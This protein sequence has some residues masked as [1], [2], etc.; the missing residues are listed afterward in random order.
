M[1]KN[2]PVFLL[3]TAAPIWAS[4]QPAFEAGDRSL[5]L[6]GGD[7]SL[8]PKLEEHGVVFKD[9]GAAEDIFKIFRAHNANCV[10]LRLFVHPDGRNGVV[11]DLPYT[12]ALAQ[13]VKAAGLLFS[14]DFH[15]SDTWAD[16]AHQTRPAAWKD[17]SFP[18]L[19]IKARQYTAETLR[20]FKDAGVPPDVVQIGNEI[21]NGMMWP[22]TDF[23][24]KSTSDSIHFDRL[25]Q[26]LAAC[27]EGVHLGLGPD[28]RTKIMIHLSSGSQKAITQWFFDNITKRRVAFDIIGLSYYPFWAGNLDQ[29][30]ETLR[31]TALTYGKPVAVVETAY[32]HED[33]PEWKGK[34][35]LVWPHTP[36]G[37]RIYLHDL[38][39]AVR[40]TPRG[41][42]AG[43][44]YWY[45]ESIAGSPGSWFEGQLALFDRNGNAL[46]ALQEF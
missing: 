42:G 14:L 45:P 23:E 46:P 39:A 2:F 18:E 7:I 10:R 40:E 8:A 28:S 4:V 11:N 34:K 12:I 17:L 25:A 5:F 1:T 3:L 29:L 13:R 19:V 20:A 30:K 38:I 33:S 21:T 37:Q 31:F 15:Y 36:D 27:G 24:D 44:L 6:L 32:P 26:L 22:G 35:N 16:P 43:V 9:N 41:L